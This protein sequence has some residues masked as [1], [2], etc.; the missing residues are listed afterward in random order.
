MENAVARD[1]SRGQGETLVKVVAQKHRPTKGI[2]LNLKMVEWYLFS[3]PYY[4]T[5]VPV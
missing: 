1:G 3:T 4:S 5:R 2:R